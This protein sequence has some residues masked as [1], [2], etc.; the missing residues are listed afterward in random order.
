MHQLADNLPLAFKRGYC[1]AYYFCGVN[2]ELTN[3]PL[4]KK[5]YN[6]GLDMGYKDRQNGV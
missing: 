1:D 2:L 3:D 6:E 4:T 5:D